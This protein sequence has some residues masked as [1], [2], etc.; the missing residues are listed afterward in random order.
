M[1]WRYLVPNLVTCIS[2]A[3][4]LVAITQATAGN[5]DGACWSVLWCVLLDKADGT[6]ARLLNASSAFGMQMDSLSDLITFGIAPATIMLAAFAGN[7]PVLVEPPFPQYRYVVYVGAF[8]YAICSALRL[9]KFN[10]LTETYG[11]DYFFGLPTTLA[12]ALVCTC[13]LTAREHN[14][15]PAY[16]A[17]LPGLAFVLASW[18]ISRLPLPKLIVRKSLA[19]NIFQFANVACT[20]V[21]GFARIFPEYLFCCAA[22]Y[23]LI[24]TPYALSKGIKPPGPDAESRPDAELD[25]DAEL[26]PEPEPSTAQ[27]ESPSE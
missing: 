11:K 27:T 20:Y 22:L 3:L 17:A 18:K 1:S 23:V 9:A 14:L 10:V 7:N 12:G 25:G 19:T 8:S 15:P 16:L 2:I 13:F 4:G 24:G 5:Y 6:A 26:D 21:F